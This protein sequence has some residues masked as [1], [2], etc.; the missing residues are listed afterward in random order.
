MRALA[1]KK[2]TSLTSSGLDVINCLGYPRYVRL[3]IVSIEMRGT[4]QRRT[5]QN[6]C[7]DSTR[8][9]KNTSNNKRTQSSRERDEKPVCASEPGLDAAANLSLQVFEIKCASALKTSS[10]PFRVTAVHVRCM[11]VHPEQQHT[12]KTHIMPSASFWVHK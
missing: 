1:Q 9:A 12:H 6:R 5:A 11:C 3:L 10:A 2:K 8:Y 7:F 4:A